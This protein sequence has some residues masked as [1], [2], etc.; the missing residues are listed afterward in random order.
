[1]HNIYSVKTF[2]W[3]VRNPGKFCNTSRECYLSLQ[4][5]AKERDRLKFDMPFL[6]I[7]AQPP[8]ILFFKWSRLV[9]H[10][11][12]H[13]RYSLH[14]TLSKHSPSVYSFWDSIISPVA[15]HY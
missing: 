7:C 4:V 8:T 15:L 13:F 2:E 10:I 5:S 1:M 9:I 12:T 3:L 14:L 6:A 11:R